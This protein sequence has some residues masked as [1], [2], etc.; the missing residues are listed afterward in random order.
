MKKTTTQKISLILTFILISFLGVL[1]INQYYVEQV[2]V[3]TRTYFKEESWQAYKTQLPENTLA[4]GFFGDSMTERGVYPPL[5]PHSFN[6]AIQAEDFIETYYRYQHITNQ[7]NISTVVIQVSMHSFS[8]EYQRPEHRLYTIHESGLF[9]FKEL[10]THIDQSTPY[11]LLR[12]HLPAIGLGREILRH[13]A[14]TP[15]PTT[16]GWHN[17]TGNYSLQPHQEKIHERIF[18]N[19]FPTQSYQEDPLTKEFFLQLLREAKANNQNIILVIYPLEEQTAQYFATQNV[20]KQN[21]IYKLISEIEAITTNYTLL[22]YQD[23]FGHR[24]DHFTDPPHLNYQGALAFTEQLAQDLE[25][26]S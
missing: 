24:Q 20:T 8:K 10:K 15:Y 2:E 23:L 16:L 4:Y 1:F 19:F 21:T 7:V 3:S 25:R 5:I 9:T 26:I 22:D 17:T 14:F 11:L 12:I 13:A 6:F 18:N